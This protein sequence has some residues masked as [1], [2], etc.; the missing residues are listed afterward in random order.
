MKRSE[1]VEHITRCLTI[2]PELKKLDNEKLKIYANCLL[3]QV[4]DYGMLP[5]ENPTA[6]NSTKAAEEANEWE[7]GQDMYDFNSKYRLR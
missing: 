2:F 6:K 4:E 5:P 7:H 1:M 3:N